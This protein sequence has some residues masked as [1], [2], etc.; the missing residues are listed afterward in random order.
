MSNFVHHDRVLELIK[1]KGPLGVNEL[2]KALS[3]PVTTLQRQLHNQSFFKLNNNKKWDLATNVA[4]ETVNESLKDFDSVIQSQLDG[5][6]A[7]FGMLSS[8]INSTITLLSSQK[9]LI[10]PVADTTVNIHPKLKELDKS[11]KDVGVVFNKY[12]DKVP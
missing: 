9:A 7:L 8:N 3:V 2:A 1:E 10:R 4:N 5:I 12:V 6:N 11:I